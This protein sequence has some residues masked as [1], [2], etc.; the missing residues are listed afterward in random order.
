MPWVACFI[1]MPRWLIPAIVA[2]SSVPAFAE[3]PLKPLN[4]RVDG[5]ER[6]GL[7]FVPKTATK[8]DCPLVFVFHGHNG[9]ALKAAKAFAI[10]EYW[11]D[12]LCV[13]LQGLPTPTDGDPEGKHTGWQR[14][15]GESGDRD[16]RF[17]DAALA[18]LKQQYQVD[19]DRIYATGFSNG[20]YFTFLLWAD[21]GDTFAAV[22]T[23]AAHAGKYRNE[24]K[25]KPYLHVAG[26]N[27]AKVSFQT[28]QKTMDFVRKLNN[29]EDTG[30][31]WNK[32]ATKA[33]A[34]RYESKSGTP[35]VGVVHPGG[36]EVPSPVGGRITARFFREQKKP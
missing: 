25:P 28:Q 14:E 35:F 21:R 3:A 6:E 10:H 31:I 9:T 20:G 11:S 8:A 34:T 33:T 7:M 16:L 29:C 26:Q 27:D 1:R 5:V 19:D 22:A 12:A 2:A 30:E 4:I 17:F 15:A 13:Y 32:P 18:R 36:H 23:C 24:L